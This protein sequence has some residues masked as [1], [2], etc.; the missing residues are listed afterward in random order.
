[1]RALT[2][3]KRPNLGA[4]T[5]FR[6]IAASLVVGF[7]TISVAALPAEVASAAT[8][9]V[10]NCS[11]SASTSGSLPAVVQSASPGDT[12][13]F[14]LSPSCSLI[15]LASTIAL[16]NF[17]TITGPGAGTLAV[18]G[19]GAVEVF[20]VPGVTASIS[21]LTI[22]D[23]N[24]G[25]GGGGGILNTG[26]L[27][28]TSSSISGNT[29]FT[30]GGIL[31]NGTLTV[32]NSSISGNSS[33]GT[34]NNGGGGI[35]STGSISVANSSVS[36]NTSGFDGGGVNQNS[37]TLTISASTV[38][39]NSA[40]SGGGIFVGN[41][42]GLSATNSTLSGNTAGSGGGIYSG[43]GPVNL[44][45]STLSANG[46][47][48][49]FTHGGTVNL[50]ATIVAN[51][52][53]SGSC[54]S[55]GGVFNDFGYNLNDDG[56]CGF[57]AT[58]HSLSG[59]NP[60][61]GHLQDNGGPTKTLAPE[62]DSPVLDQIPLGTKAN[63]ATLCPGADQ[64]GVTRPQGAECDIGAVELA[65]GAT[66]PQA[67][68]FTSTPP[69]GATA[70]GPDYTV[71]A[72]GGASG[73]PV[74]FSV[75]G[76]ASAVC[77][78]S[79]SVVTFIGAGTCTIDANQAGNASYSAAPQVQQSFSVGLEAR[80][81]TSPN[82]AT[83]TTGTPFSFTVTTTGTPVPLITEKGKLPKGI[84]FTNNGNGT[85]TVSGTPKKAG[86]NHLT[87]AA[88]FGAGT[89]RYIV[90]QAFTLAIVAG[91]R[92]SP[93]PRLRAGRTLGEGTVPERPPTQR[94]HLRSDD[95]ST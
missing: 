33:T 27:T 46:A 54:G 60:K 83:A 95:A 50:A 75:D 81:I 23:G 34:T 90:T 56:S 59:V 29:A 86:V 11:G 19:G 64:R 70:E 78:V 30:G 65:T 66:T 25:G 55:F 91:S 3:P 40:G 58:N 24:V 79:G 69:S 37:G 45:A 74:I 94:W 62:L 61:L 53:T 77:S 68:R 49:I 21:G 82:S 41:S 72:T 12:V 26:T 1:M 43:G 28:V 42:G 57:S 10:T 6:L 84:K 5:K 17:L 93:G 48:S 36:G 67:I 89:T 88:T 8:D 51:S 4:P 16:K 7:T 39:G 18:S 32:T 47:G 22:E 71:S 52:T 35:Y 80:A 44:I 87:L 73:N 92:P 20:S 76:S 15:T 14:A 13:T 38:S 2:T 63:G 85:A 9:T 31:N